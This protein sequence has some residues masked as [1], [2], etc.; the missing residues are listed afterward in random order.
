MARTNRIPT[1]RETILISGASSGLGAAMARAWAATGHSLALVA[2]RVERLTTIREELQRSYP[3]SRVAVR[4]LDVRDADAVRTVFGDLDTELGGI[5]RF[6]LN[7]GI[8]KGA[9]VGT[10]TAW[11]NAETATINALG[12][13]N[14]AEVALEILRPRG[15]GHLVFVSS[16]AAQRGMLRAETTYAASKAFVSSLAQGI[17]AE[18]RRSESAIRVSTICPGY[19]DTDMTRGNSSPL[20]ADLDA[21]VA[22]MVAAIDREVVS[23]AVPSWPWAVVSPALKYLPEPLTRRFI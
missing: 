5:D 23:A 16:V 20:K 19:I 2:R 3:G 11:A 6:V 14:Q 7:A 13:L 12:T 8:G 10:G 18:L 15:E 22:A 21:G 9:S 4:Q 1:R 17:H